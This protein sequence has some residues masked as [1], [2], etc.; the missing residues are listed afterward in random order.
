MQNLAVARR[1]ARALYDLAAEQQIIDAIEQDLGRVMQQMAE[2]RELKQV[3]E[4]QAISPRAK[5]ELV[6]QAFTDQIGAVTLNFL[7]VVVQRRRELYL[8]AMLEEYTRLADEGRGRVEV[9]VRA[10]V[11]MPAE[12]RDNLMQALQNRLGKTVKLSAELDPRLMG[13]V[14]VQVGD[15]LI[16]GSIRTRLKRIGQRLRRVRVKEQ[17]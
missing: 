15:T 13:G 5:W 4:H 17:G 11:E 1:Y 2:N 16:D 10:A 6:R 14:V 8:A 12:S 3:I 9:R 7:G